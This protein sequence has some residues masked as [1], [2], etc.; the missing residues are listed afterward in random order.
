MY[1]LCFKLTTDNTTTAVINSKELYDCKC[2]P[3]TL[4]NNTLYTAAFRFWYLF[5]PDDGLHGP[6]LVAII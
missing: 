6:K 2:D 5:W 4:T 3:M 1:N